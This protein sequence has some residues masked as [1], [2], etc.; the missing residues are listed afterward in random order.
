MKPELEGVSMPTSEAPEKV[1]LVREKELR[2]CLSMAVDR[3]KDIEESRSTGSTFMPQCEAAITWAEK[4]LSIPAP[5]VDSKED[6][7]D[8]A[9]L[10]VIDE[11]DAAEEA[12]SQAYYLITGSSP[13]WSNRFGYKEALEDIDDAQQLLRK[14]LAKPSPLEGTGWDTI[15]IQKRIRRWVESRLGMDAMDAHERATRSLEENNELGQSLGVTR[16]E[17]HKIVD[18]VFDKEPGNPEQELGGAALTLLGCADGAGHVL[19]Q[20][21]GKELLRIESLP[22]DKFRKRQT[23]NAANGIGAPPVAPIEEK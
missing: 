6:Q 8:R 14:S 19:S 13:H 12:L 1:E 23:E 2:E 3:M 5:K 11:R 18:H 9:I 10:Q 7:D 21:A 22:W 17:A 16:E 15:E 20:C 4:L